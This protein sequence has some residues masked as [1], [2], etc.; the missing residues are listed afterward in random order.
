[1]AIAHLIGNGPSKALFKVGSITCDPITEGDV[2]G[3]NLGDFA[4]PLKA[5][6]IMDAV[7]L[8]HVMEKHLAL[9]WPIIIQHNLE[10]I[11]LQCDPKPV[12]LDRIH[13]IL[14]NGENCGMYAMQYLVEKGYSEIQLWGFDSL[15]ID[16]VISDS[17]QKMPEAPFWPRN[18]ERWRPRWKKIIDAAKLKNVKVILHRPDAIEEL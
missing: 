16:S 11:V 7:V 12:V 14:E 3:C 13:K 17:H 10:K 4:L 15:W 9:P 18:W 8:I 5:S 2:F 1:V 6:V